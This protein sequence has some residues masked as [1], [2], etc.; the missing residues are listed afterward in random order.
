MY[1]EKLYHNCHHDYS[2]SVIIAI[3]IE[4]P[5]QHNRKHILAGK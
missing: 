4:C 3:T 1:Y 2:L 5:N